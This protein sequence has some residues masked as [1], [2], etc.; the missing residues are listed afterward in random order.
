MIPRAF[1]KNHSNK[2]CFQNDLKHTERHFFSFFDWMEF[3]TWIF[4]CKKVDFGK[5]EKVGAIRVEH[6]E[7]RKPG[8][9]RVDGAIRVG[10][11]RV[12]GQ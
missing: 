10:A 9:I 8:A 11:I 12:D 6:S 4:G 2:K 7:A 1:K 5:A 3:L